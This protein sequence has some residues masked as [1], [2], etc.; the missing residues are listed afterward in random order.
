MGKIYT[1]LICALISAAQAQLTVSE[2]IYQQMQAR[3]SKNAL[4]KSR[5]SNSPEAYIYTIAGSREF[6]PGKNFKVEKLDNS[7]RFTPMNKKKSKTR[8]KKWSDSEMRTQALADIKKILPKDIA[9]S[10]AITSVNYEFEQR[11]DNEPRTVG[12]IVMVHRLLDGSPV[13]G[14]SYVLANYDSTG[15]LSY[16]DVQW[17]VFNKIPA[18][19]TL[20]TTKKNEKFK[21]NFSKLVENVS[22]DFKKHELKGSFDN[23]VESFSTI[24]NQDGT[25]MLVPSITFIGQYSNK[26]EEHSIP[27]IF[28]IPTDASL[29]S[30]K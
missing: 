9:D 26:E 20:N 23:S 22:E 2:K 11:D 16:M 19:S 28:D 10:C 8:R 18:K 15:N 30:V 27:M 3:E 7:H 17:D 29:I 4:M 21:T 5:S 12:S 14:N 25:V 6:K 24:E 1:L 13:R